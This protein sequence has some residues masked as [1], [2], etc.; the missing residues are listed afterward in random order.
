MAACPKRLASGLA[1][2]LLLSLVALLPG[3][4]QAQGAQGA[5]GGQGGQGGADFGV[6][7]RPG[8]RWKQLKEVHAALEWGGKKP[9]EQRETKWIQFE[10]F[11]GQRRTCSLGWKNVW[12][13]RR[14]AH[15]IF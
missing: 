3:P 12:G 2:L 13:G 8:T 10:G 6:D 14:E 4:A 15:G 7:S 9:L 5:Q 1:C 11:Q